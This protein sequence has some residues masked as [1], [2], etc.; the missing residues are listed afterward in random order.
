MVSATPMTV[1]VDGEH[2]PLG[3]RERRPA[4]DLRPPGV[5]HELFRSLDDRLDLAP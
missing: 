4:S 5:T 2:H 3:K 1:S